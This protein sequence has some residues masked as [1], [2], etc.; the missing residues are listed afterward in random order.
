M[1]IRLAASL[2]IEGLDLPEIHRADDFPLIDYWDG[3][4][5]T[6]LHARQHPA[7]EHQI[8][9]AI[10]GTRNRPRKRSRYQAWRSDGSK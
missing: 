3:W 6:A 2:L 10:E 5:V 8:H 9:L 1:A 7:S 4:Q